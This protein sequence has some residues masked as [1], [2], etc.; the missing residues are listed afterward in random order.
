M[1][2]DSKPR[3]TH[4]DTERSVCW[5][6]VQETFSDGIVILMNL[7]RVSKGQTVKYVKAYTDWLRY[8]KWGYS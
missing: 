8:Q 1:Q 7:I 6:K 3:R 2:G 5:V 4:V